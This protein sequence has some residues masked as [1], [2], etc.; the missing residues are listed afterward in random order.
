MQ[1]EKVVLA[2]K[3]ID[4]VPYKNFLFLVFKFFYGHILIT[5]KKMY[6]KTYYG[7]QFKGKHLLHVLQGTKGMIQ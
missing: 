2:Q 4:K 1:Q 6:K 3:N 5:E 7:R